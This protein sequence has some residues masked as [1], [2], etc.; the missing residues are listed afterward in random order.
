M[1]SYPGLR[2]WSVGNYVI[3][4]RQ[5]STGI[6]IV[7]VLHGARDIEALFHDAEAGSGSR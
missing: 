1:P 3:F 5:V 2:S 7:R 4:Y 6:D